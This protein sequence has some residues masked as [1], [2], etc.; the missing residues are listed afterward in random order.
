MAGIKSTDC[1][2]LIPAMGSLPA[3]ISNCNIVELYNYMRACMLVCH[4]IVLIL[5]DCFKMLVF[6]RKSV[7]GSNIHI[8]VN[9]V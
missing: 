1:K 3:C 8:E 4:C 6:I 7:I 9:A 2:D 5:M